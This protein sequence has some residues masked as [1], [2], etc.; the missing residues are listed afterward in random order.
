MVNLKINKIEKVTTTDKKADNK[1]L[2]TKNCINANTIKKVLMHTNTKSKIFINLNFDILLCLTKIVI[3]KHTSKKM[4]VISKKIC[5]PKLNILT[6]K[7][8]YYKI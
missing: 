6:S 5:N 3:N 1:K 7:I 2:P 8:N 4:S